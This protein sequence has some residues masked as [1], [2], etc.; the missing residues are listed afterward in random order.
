MK[1][2]HTFYGYEEISDILF[3]G[4]ENL[5]TREQLHLLNLTVMV[6]SRR[7]P[8]KWEWNPNLYTMKV[9]NVFNKMEVNEVL[10]Q[11]MFDAADDMRRGYLNEKQ[12]NV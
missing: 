8:P 11:V 7:L 5:D 9:P 1:I 2:L 4:L 10:R 12:G 3:L 6:M